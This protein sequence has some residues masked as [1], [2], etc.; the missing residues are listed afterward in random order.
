V[1]CCVVV[2]VVAY[3]FNTKERSAKVGEGEKESTVTGSRNKKLENKVPSN[4][5]YHTFRI[6]AT[7]IVGQQQFLKRMQRTN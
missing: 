2:R 5:N 3:N 7:I 1:S 6:F 4:N